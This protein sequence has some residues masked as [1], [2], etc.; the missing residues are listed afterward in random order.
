M[1]WLLWILFFMSASAIA[2][3]DLKTRLISLWLIL[4]FGAVTI[5]LYLNNHSV[6]ELAENMLF[7]L[8]YFL[9]SYLVLQLFYVVK[10]KK[11][12]RLLDTK[13]GLGDVVLYFVVGSCFS[14]ADMVLFFTITFITALAFHFIFLRKSKTVALGAFLMI[15]YSVQ[16]AY[17]SCTPYL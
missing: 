3:Q 10:T 9:F 2:Y 16:L 1:G 4:V 12:T 5:A 15:C 11:C 6:R 17:S 7:C 14:P 13:I 8:L